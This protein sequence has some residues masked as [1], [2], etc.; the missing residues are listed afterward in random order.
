MFFQLLFLFISTF[1]NNKNAVSTNPT[2][3]NTEYVNN[4]DNEVT[5]QKLDFIQ[6]LEELINLKLNNHTNIIRFDLDTKNTNITLSPHIENYIEKNGFQIYSINPAPTDSTNIN[7]DRYGYSTCINFIVD[8]N[9]NIVFTDLDQKQS[10]GTYD[11]INDNGVFFKY[12]LGEGNPCGYGSSIT[13]NLY[14]WESG[15]IITQTIDESG[16]CPDPDCECES[17]DDFVNNSITMYS[18][19]NVLMN[20]NSEELQKYFET[21]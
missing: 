13:T 16:Y 6:D 19:N 8:N 14:L 15:N 21:K 17:M 1:V 20:N 18:T 5:E 10:I 4:Y 11:Q 7:C 2:E 12:L 3:I 9:N